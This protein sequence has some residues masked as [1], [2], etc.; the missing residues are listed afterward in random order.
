MATEKAARK[1]RTKKAVEPI[2][3][4]EE[5]KLENVFIDYPEPPSVTLDEVETVTEIEPE[6]SETVEVKEPEPVE[7]KQEEVKAVINTEELSMEERILAYLEDKP[8]AEIKMNDFIKSLFKAPKY[9][10]PPLWSLQPASKEIRNI[11][12]KIQKSGF[13]EISG[14]AHLKLGVTHY[15]DTSTMKAEKHTLNSVPIYVKKVN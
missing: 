10:E 8:K 6:L 3:G 4:T 14:N 15:P 11:L 9:G 12:E 13:I 2:L 5:D 7:I 1:P